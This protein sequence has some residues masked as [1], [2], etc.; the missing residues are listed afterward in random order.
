ML[1]LDTVD[2]ED[3]VRD[4]L[5]PRVTEVVGDDVGVGVSDIVDVADGGGVSEALAPRVTDAVGEAVTVEEGEF[6]RD[7]DAVKDE[8][9]VADGVLVELWDREAGQPEAYVI[10]FEQGADEE[11]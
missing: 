11:S 6:E 9:L 8:V 10:R 7:F 5:A 4:A 1:E 3:S 2:D